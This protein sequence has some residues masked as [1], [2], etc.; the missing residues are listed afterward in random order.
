MLVSLLLLLLMRRINHRNIIIKGQDNL[1]WA[2]DLQVRPTGDTCSRH[3]MPSSKKVRNIHSDLAHLFAKGSMPNEIG[4]HLFSLCPAEIFEK[5]LASRRQLNILL[6]LVESV[7][8]GEQRLKRI[9]RR[10]HLR[11]C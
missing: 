9:R 8:E 10:R 3:Q 6:V 4:L 5:L 2:S 11:R 7:Q 1:T